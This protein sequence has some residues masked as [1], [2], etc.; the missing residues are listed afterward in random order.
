MR[1]LI[2]IPP[3][4]DA[5]GR[6]KPGRAY[7]YLDAAYAHAIAEAGADAVVIPG[8]SE[9]DSLVARL[10]GLLVPG[11]DDLL[12][13]RPYPE[14]VRFTPVPAPQLAFDRRLLEAALER[15]LPVLGICY[16]MQLLALHCGGRLHYDIGTDLGDAGDHRLAEDSGRHGLRVDGGSRLARVLGE[17][18]GPVNSLHHQAV[19]EPGNGARVSAWAPDGVIEAI[20]LDRPDFAIGVQWHPEKLGEEHRL[21]LF[22]GFVGACGRVEGL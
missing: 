6:W 5:E 10:D 2:G 13:D 12:P 4:L 9:V 16:G 22:G 18:P 1:P 20:E 14:P 21:R 19:A 3:C 17:S 15:G 7:H 8:Q 11:G